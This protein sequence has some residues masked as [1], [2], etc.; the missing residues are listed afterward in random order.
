MQIYSATEN[1]AFFDSLLPKIIGLALRLP[2]LITNGIPLL[3]RDRTHSV[4]L[5]QLQV[6]CLLANAFLCTYPC[7][8]E[9]K[10]KNAEYKDYPTINL[11]EYWL[12]SIFERPSFKIDHFVPFSLF[13][14]F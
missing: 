12:F 4:S 10:K 6:A 1:K 11:N 3:K 14:E 2:E 9:G 13:G 7:R 8:N 5:S